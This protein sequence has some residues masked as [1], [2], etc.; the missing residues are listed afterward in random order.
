[1]RF[2]YFYII[3]EGNGHVQSLI[4]TAI[5]LIV[6]FQVIMLGVLADLMGF[7]RKMQEETLYRLRKMQVDRS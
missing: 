6:G 7:S 3:G 1:M 5:L 4:L 2:L